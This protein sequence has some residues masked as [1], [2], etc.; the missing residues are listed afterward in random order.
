M[1][2][3][4][5]GLRSWG[6]SFPS[7]FILWFAQDSPGLSLL[8]LCSCNGSSFTIKSVQVWVIKN[9]SASLQLSE[10]KAVP[11]ILLHAW[12]VSA[13]SPP[14]SWFRHCHLLPE[15]L[16]LPSLWSP[17]FPCLSLAIH[18][19]NN[20]LIHPLKIHALS[21]RHWFLAALSTQFKYLSMA[22]KSL[23]SPESCFCLQSSIFWFLCM[24]SHF[25]SHWVHCPLTL[26]FGD[27][28]YPWRAHTWLTNANPCACV[29]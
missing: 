22:L 13:S 12:H 15:L 19:A 18:S 11:P 1:L 7:S 26:P 6:Q 9:W 24:K 10:P 5:S 21:S 3:L 23:C 8:S 4:S 2:F 17:Y 20:C 28:A 27:Y 29:F 16:Q 14:P 25:H